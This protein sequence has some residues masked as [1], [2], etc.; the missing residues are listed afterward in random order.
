MTALAHAVAV[1]KGKR[2]GRGYGSARRAPLILRLG[3][4]LLLAAAGCSS[5]PARVSQGRSE[6][7][8]E[9]TSVRSSILNRI[10]DGSGE[11]SLTVDG[12]RDPP[13]GDPA[14]AQGHYELVSADGRMSRN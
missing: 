9:L 5:V 8:I 7:A 1:A 4:L 2:M 10:G 12:R 14:M 3:A 11:P 13:A 6:D